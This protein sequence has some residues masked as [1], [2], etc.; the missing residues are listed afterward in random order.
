MGLWSEVLAAKTSTEKIGKREHHSG[1][2]TARSSLS[3]VKV[4]S[5]LRL[6]QVKGEPENPR[7]PNLQ[8]SRASLKP[9]NWDSFLRFDPS[10]SSCMTTSL[11]SPAHIQGIGWQVFRNFSK[12]HDSARLAH[13]GLP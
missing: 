9:V 8:T 6:L 5:D 11:K 10:F 2:A 1:L 13:T 3:F 7:S 4:S 12:S